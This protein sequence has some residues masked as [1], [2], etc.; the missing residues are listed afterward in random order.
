MRVSGGV[1]G[2]RILERLRAA[3]HARAGC[4]SVPP[5]G[6]QVSVRTTGF[7]PIAPRAVIVSEVEGCC[8]SAAVLPHRG[9]GEGGDGDEDERAH[10]PES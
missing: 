6:S 9:S 2:E 10:E 1:G 7:A 3:R 4:R 5:G 8:G